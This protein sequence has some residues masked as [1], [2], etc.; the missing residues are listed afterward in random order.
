MEGT[1]D[2]NLGWRG[3]IK[4]KINISEPKLLVTINKMKGSN[5]Y[6]NKVK[7]LQSLL[8]MLT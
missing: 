3:S 1:K 2:G 4:I 7:M 5:K 8:L 6:I